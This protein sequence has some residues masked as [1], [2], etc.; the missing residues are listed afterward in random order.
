M[1]ANAYVER[2]ITPIATAIAPGPRRGLPATG[3]VAVPRGR[4]A[5][6]LTPNTLRCR[7]WPDRRAVSPTHLRSRWIRRYSRRAAWWACT[8]TRT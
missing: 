3:D 8:A 4:G 7:A 5:P 1:M 6:A 2:F